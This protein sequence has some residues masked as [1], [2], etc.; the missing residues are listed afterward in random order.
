MPLAPGVPVVLGLGLSNGIPATIAVE[1][2]VWM[3][4]VVLYVRKTR[5]ASRA[6][7]TLSWYSNITKGSGVGVLDEPRAA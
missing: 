3:L 6:L 2:G 4:A 5:P 7:L 1:G